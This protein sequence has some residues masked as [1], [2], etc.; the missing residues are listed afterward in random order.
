MDSN[1]ARAKIKKVVSFIKLL[2]TEC[3]EHFVSVLLNIYLI[4]DLRDLSILIDQ[5]RFSSGAHVRLSVHTFLAPDTVALDYR[6]IGVGKQV[7]LKAVLRAELLMSFLIVNGDAEQLDILFVEFV[8]RITERTCFLGS[9]RCVVFRIKEQ[10][11]ALALEVGK[12][13]RVAVLIFR[14]KVWCLIA[15]FEHK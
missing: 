3:R 2:L 5:K 12:F 11:D 13:Y 1:A 8:V 6:F 14:F 15:F 4:K 10:D 7:E 9:A